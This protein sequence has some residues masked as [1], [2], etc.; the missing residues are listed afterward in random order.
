MAKSIT[1]NSADPRD[2][3]STPSRIQEG[4]VDNPRKN[5]RGHNEQLSEPGNDGLLSGLPHRSDGSP[6]YDSQQS[7]PLAT[8]SA[9]GKT[10]PVNE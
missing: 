5:Y 7:S 6:R 3:Q 9:T 2:D 4:G 8:P 1:K 10:Q